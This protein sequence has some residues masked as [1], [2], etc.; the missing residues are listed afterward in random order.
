MK[1]RTAVLLGTVVV[2][3]VAAG[4]VYAWHRLATG[5]KVTEVGVAEAL[6]RYREQID[7]TTTAPTRRRPC[8]PRPRSTP[9]RQ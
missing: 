9:S 8:R 7:A 1:R 3:V 5:G 4:G 2:L 6:D